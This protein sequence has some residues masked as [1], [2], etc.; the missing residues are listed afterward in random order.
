MLRRVA[1]HYNI[2]MDALRVGVKERN[3]VKVR[4]A[5]CYLAV[6]K[7]KMSAVEVALELNITPSAVSKSVIR[8]QSI[9]R[10]TELVEN[11]IKC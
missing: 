6:R 10:Q 8:G 2:D 5:L 11:L 7:L 9:L 1:D 4:S 3:T